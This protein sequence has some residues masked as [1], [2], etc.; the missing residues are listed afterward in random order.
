MLVWRN[1][2]VRFALVELR[3]DLDQISVGM[4][5]AKTNQENPCFC[6][7]VKK[8]G[9][10]TRRLPRLVSHED[11]L[12]M[13]MAS[14]IVIHVSKETLEDILQLLK[15]DMRKDKAMHGRVLD[16]PL[17]IED[18]VTGQAVQL[19]KNDRLE[20]EGSCPDVHCRMSDFQGDGPFALVFWRRRDD[21]HNLTFYTW[22]LRIRGVRKEN[23]VLDI[24][25]TLDLGAASRLFGAIAV[26]ALK[27]GDLGNSTTEQGIKLGCAELTSL[28]KKWYMSE[29]IRTR[30]QKLTPA[31]LSIGS[32]GGHLKCKAV[33]ARAVLP[34]SLKLLDLSRNSPVTRS[35]R[36]KAV[37]A[38]LAAYRLMSDSDRDI[39]LGKLSKLL[40]SCHM[41]SK[42][43]K[44]SLIP[45]FHFMRH[46]KDVAVNHGNPRFYSAYSDE[47]HNKNMV[48]I[49]QASMHPA[50]IA[51]RVLTRETLL[52]RLRT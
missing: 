32:T 40:T 5:F 22:L 23:L 4:G 31:M 2:R 49:A 18:V 48:R 34:F 16:K 26:T 47:S 3:A 14:R 13:V 27:S 51:R 17:S 46:L 7:R 41:H 45:K 30:L 29:K 33:E 11:Y 50:L 42:L 25:H 15:F 35:H 20:P 19:L 6:C 9:M 24:L 21:L 38:L 8:G 37:M 43:G 52:S 1:Q 36:R 44:I 39:H 28:A 12:D 10:H